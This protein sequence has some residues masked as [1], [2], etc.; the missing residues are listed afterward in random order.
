MEDFL[1]RYA[2][3]EDIPS[4]KIFIDEEWKKNHIF[5]REEGLFEWQYTSDKLDY[6]LGLD[7][8]GNI[9]GMLGFISYDDSKERDIAT[10][11]WKAMPGTGFL[12]VKLLM[13]IMQNEP[14]RSLFSP[15]INVKT[16]GG[17]Y[18]RLG[19]STGRM[20]QWYRI[21][22]QERYHIAKITDGEIPD[23]ELHK[24]KA[25]KF[26]SLEDMLCKFEFDKYVSKEVVPYKSRAYL[27]RRY[28]GHPLYKYLIYGLAID[29]EDISV[30]I[31]ARIQNCN[32]TCAIRLVD[33]L[34]D[35]NKI[36]YI[37]AFFDDLLEEYSAEYIDFYEKGIDGNLLKSAGWKKRDETGNII[38]NYFSPFERTNVEV[39]YCTTDDSIV[40]FRGDGD[41]DRPN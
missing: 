23:Y 27:Q 39:N 13:H 33:C 20:N 41:Q 9:Q 10:S 25:F 8:D 6:V 37:T 28:F 34:G 12:G 3:I 36:G 16:S 26:E 18:R 19:I 22:K 35:Y 17:I 2:T 30:V 1:I 11:M 24:T 5:V 38:P 31:V 29:D 15:G 4:I 32:G 40:L 14:H 7:S 21:H